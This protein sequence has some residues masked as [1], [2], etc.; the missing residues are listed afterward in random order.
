MRNQLSEQGRTYP[1]WLRLLY[2][3]T[4]AVVLVVSFFMFAFSGGDVRVVSFILRKALPSLVQPLWLFPVL[5]TA[6]M[7]AISSAQV[8]RSKR[9]TVFAMMVLVLVPLVAIIGSRILLWFYTNQ[10]SAL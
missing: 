7:I 5:A 9:T 4:L 8:R 6:V 3:I 2:G 1:T 10:S